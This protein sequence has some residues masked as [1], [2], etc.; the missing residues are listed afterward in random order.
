MF[1]YN[2]YREILNN[3]NEITFEKIKT[4]FDISNKFLENREVDEYSFISNK[5]HR[6]SVYFMI[7]EED[8]MKI[9]DNKMLSD[10]TNLDK[11][12]TVFFSLTEREFGSNFNNLTNKNEYLEVLGKVVFLI[13]EYINRHNYQVYSFGVVSNKKQDFYNNYHKYFNDF[14]RIYGVSRYYNEEN[15]LFMI[16]DI[17]TLSGV[18]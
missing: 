5:G 18:R 11:I 6:Y 14:L 1:N 13:R 4:S 3:L 15:C 10:Y 12:T 7:T 9:S 17:N 2:N 8:D 16:K